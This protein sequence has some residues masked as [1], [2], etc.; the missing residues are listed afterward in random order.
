VDHLV[1]IIGQRYAT[2]LLDL[3]DTVWAAVDR[4]LNRIDLDEHFLVLVVVPMLVVLMVMM[5]P[6]LM[7]VLMATTFLV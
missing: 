7:V 6:I 1:Q 5:V 4:F 3:D 2:E